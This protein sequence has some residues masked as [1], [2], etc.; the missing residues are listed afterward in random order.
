MNYQRSEEIF[1][2]ILYTGLMVSILYKKT[3]VILYYSGV[4]NSMYNTHLHTV[5]NY[6]F[7]FSKCDTFGCGFRIQRSRV[8]RRGK[9]NIEVLNAHWPDSCSFTKSRSTNHSLS[10]VDNCINN[11]GDGWLQLLMSFSHNHGLP[12]WA[13]SITM[14][15]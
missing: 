4:F 7:F 6:D 1:P 3:L 8:N 11:C 2:S 14:Q 9:C 15:L 5:I 10:R 13:F 12:L